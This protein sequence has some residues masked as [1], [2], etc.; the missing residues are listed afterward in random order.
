MS[1]HLTDDFRSIVLHDTPLLDVR[2]PVEFV[3]GAFLHTTNIPILDDEERRL[4]GIK[5]KEKGNAE[6]IKLAEQLIQNE[7]KERRVALWKNYLQEHPN[8]MLFCFRGGQRSGIAQSWLEEQGI[9]ITRLKGGYKAFRN[10]LMEESLRITAKHKSIILGG[11]TG[12]GKTVLLSK[13]KESID[14]EGIANHR[15]SSFGPLTTPQPSQINFENNLAYALIHFDAKDLKHL[16]IEHESHNIG[17]AFIP[18]PLYNNLLDGELILL[19]TPMKE[20]VDITLHEYVTVAIQKY[21]E[22][23]GDHGVDKWAEDVYDNL[24]RIKK[25]LGSELYL[26]FQNIFTEA[27]NSFL[28]TKDVALFK[29]FIQR[30]LEDYYDPM[31]DYQI[32]KTKIPIIFRGNAEEVLKFLTLP[33][34]RTR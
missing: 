27:F 9:N 11:R 10:F 30:L 24:K 4:V 28:L 16:V 33:L 29:P 3:K 31:Y 13:I 22:K 6:A 23:F 26:E 12:S 21:S 19:E 18:K 17:R 25:R 8:A 5:Y 34:K 7:G 2:A 32:E 14:L 15:G 1:L 20:R